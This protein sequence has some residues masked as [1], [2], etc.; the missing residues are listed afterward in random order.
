MRIRT[1]AGMSTSI[2]NKGTR[3]QRAPLSIVKENKMQ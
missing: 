3:K 1:K 2:K